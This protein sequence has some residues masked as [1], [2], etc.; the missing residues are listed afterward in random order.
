[1]PSREFESETQAFGNPDSVKKQR[2][3]DPDIGDFATEAE[4]SR[5]ILIKSQY[6]PR[7]GS[8]HS[9]L[10]PPP[11]NSATTYIANKEGP[12]A[13][14]AIIA[15]KDCARRSRRPCPPLAATT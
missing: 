11:T 1:M 2:T 5:W 10:R 7:P 3:L 8:R 14:A 9:Q 15:K 12:N 4:A 13:S 6:R